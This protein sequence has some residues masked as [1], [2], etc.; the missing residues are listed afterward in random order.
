MKR[1]NWNYSSTSKFS[2]SVRLNEVED[3]NSGN[4][5][6]LRNNN[7]SYN[8]RRRPTVFERIH[9]K[10]NNPS[11]NNNKNNN[12]NVRYTNNQRSQANTQMNSNKNHKINTEKEG[13]VTQEW[14]NPRRPEIESKR[15][16]GI[17]AV[18]YSITM[19]ELTLGKDNDK[20][21][22][23]ESIYTGIPDMNYKKEDIEGLNNE[24][25][26]MI[27]LVKTDPYIYFDKIMKPLRESLSNNNSTK[28][29]DIDTIK[30]KLKDI[31]DEL[32]N[33]F[34]LLSKDSIIKKTYN[35]IITILNKKSKNINNINKE[36]EVLD[37]ENIKYNLESF[38]KGKF[39]VNLEFNKEFLNNKYLGKESSLNTEIHL[40]SILY[41]KQLNELHKSL[42]GN[43][44]KEND[45]IKLFIKEIEESIKNR[46]PNEKDIKLNKIENN[47]NNKKLS[48]NHK[49]EDNNKD[50][51][52]NEL[53]LD[54]LFNKLDIRSDINS[55]NSSSFL[56]DLNKN[57]EINQNNNQNQNE[58][59]KTTLN[60]ID[61][62]TKNNLRKSMGN[63]KQMYLPG[64]TYNPK[65]LSGEA[66]ESLKSKRLIRQLATKYHKVGN[67]IWKYPEFL[68]NY[69]YS[70]GYI[71]PR[72]ITGLNALEHKKISK[73]IKRARCAGLLAYNYKY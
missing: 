55:S 35:E 14:I 23:K 26:K 36:N 3:N 41:L 62:V 65:T 43:N 71:I 63:I 11:D 37:K 7:N 47:N 58:I 16:S 22:S 15:I 12:N 67:N 24:R 46:N 34:N 59:I 20:E 52:K 49:N 1:S 6:N 60:D 27:N 4:K 13:S 17:S 64:D 8:N 19:E 66:F 73:A 10:D 40:K 54:D 25:M 50:N 21:P 44:Y 39:L 5:S 18:D 56:K 45:N 29:Y 28:S 72:T 57:S 42:I 38:S 61:L 30:I 51:N 32:L 31:N 69:I 9:N 33:E 48:S 70:T 2:V 68:R 53:N